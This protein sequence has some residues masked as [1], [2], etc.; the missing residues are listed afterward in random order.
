VNSLPILIILPEY[1]QRD[2]LWLLFAQI[3][4]QGI[5]SVAERHKDSPSIKRFRK[6]EECVVESTWRD[7][8]TSG[9]VICHIFKC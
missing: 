5:V 2:L 7:S 4:R 1:Q 9:L 8:I 3:Q 6:V